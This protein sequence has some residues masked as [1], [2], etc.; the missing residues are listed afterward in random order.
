MIRSA[1]GQSQ[2]EQIGAF[3]ASHAS[4]VKD[5]FIG[6]TKV[7]LRPGVLGWLEQKR[8]DLQSKAAI[9]IQKIYRGLFSLISR[10]P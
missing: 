3:L 10:N 1:E 6:K 4:P 7:F 2:Q 9:V 5:F 8:T